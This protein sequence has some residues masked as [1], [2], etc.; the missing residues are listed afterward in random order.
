MTLELRPKVQNHVKYEGFVCVSL[1][2]YFATVFRNGSS[3]KRRVQ[4]MWHMRGDD[5]VPGIH[6]E[7]I[8][9][10]NEMVTRLPH[11]A[12]L[13][14]FSTD[15][16]CL[17]RDLFFACLFFRQVFTNFN[18]LHGDDEFSYTATAQ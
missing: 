3:R 13:L 6:S 9:R 12:V 18:D 10:L 7:N 11:L 1:F 17:E 16:F 14:S 8:E 2:H 15:A 4:Y 5:D